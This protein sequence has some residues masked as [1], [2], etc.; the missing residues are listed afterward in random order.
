MDKKTFE[1]INP[2]TEE[3][4]C[5]VSEATEKDVDLAVAAARTAF[6]GVWRQ[7]TP[8]ARSVMMLKL[9]ELVEKNTDLLAA[10]ESL[11][12]GKSI[13]MAR[14]DVGAVAG[15]IRYYGGWADKIEGKTIDI[16]P[17]MFNYTRQ[18]PVGALLLALPLGRRQAGGL[19]LTLLTW[20]PARRL[21]ADHPVELPAA[22][23]GVEDRA[24]AGDGQ[25][26][27]AQ[28]G[29]ADAAVGAR[30]RAVCQGGRLPGRR[31]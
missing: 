11:D 21:R 17:D 30:V 23:A 7:T 10:V 15:C 8:Q 2:T 24:G 18:E 31:A 5:S 14:G 22:H 9:A 1:V 27:S 20:W 13:S 25:R 26:D 4:I 12:N 6:E 19:R 3:V 29:G 28:V 16:A